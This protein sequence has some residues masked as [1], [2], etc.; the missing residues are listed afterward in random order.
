MKIGLVEM[1]KEGDQYQVIWPDG[2]M[3]VSEQEA[4]KDLH[5]MT[6]HPLRG[7]FLLHFRDQCMRSY[8]CKSYKKLLEHFLK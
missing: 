1:T 5:Y 2:G 6:L 3:V 7:S 4:I 8:D